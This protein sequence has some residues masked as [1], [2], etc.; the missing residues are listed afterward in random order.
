MQYTN[1]AFSY[2]ASQAGQIKDVA[3]ALG[4][5]EMAIAG[6]I[7]EEHDAF[8][9]KLNVQLAADAY[10]DLNLL[11]HTDIVLGVKNAKAKSDQV[12]SLFDKL[13]QPVLMDVGP[14][15]IKISTAVRLFENYSQE[16]MQQGSDP[17]GL[18]GY[19]NNYRHMLV[20]LIDQD[21]G[22]TAAMTGLMIKEADDFFSENS[23]PGYWESM[24]QEFRDAVCITYFN[25]GPAAIIKK[26]N[27]DLA[28]GKPYEPQPGEG[29][30]GGE[31]FREPENQAAIISALNDP[32][33]QLT[34]DPLIDID[35]LYNQFR[36]F[37]NLISLDKVRQAA[38]CDKST[39]VLS[40]WREKLSHP[41]S[42]SDP[43]LPSPTNPNTY[44]I[45]WIPGGDPLVL[46]LDG[47]GVETIAPN[48][49]SGALF[50]HNND[51][52]KTA[53]GWIKGDDGL[54]VRDLNGNG[55]IDNGAELFG[56][57]TR[58]ANGTK[59][60]DGFVALRDIDSNGD[61]KI[62][63]ADTAFSELKI[64]RDANQDGISQANELSTL[65]ELGIESLNATAAN[66]SF[67]PTAAGQQIITGAF[68]K[69]NGTTATLADLNLYQDNF[70]S[71]Y[72]THI[73]IPQEL[74][75]LPDEAGMG[76]LR[77][78]REAATLS[79]ALANVLTQYAAAETRTEQK[80][81]LGQLLFEWAKT[82]PNYSASPVEVINTYRNIQYDAN[83]TNVIY[84]RAGQSLPIYLQVIP[85]TY[86]DTALQQHTRVVDAALGDRVTTILFDI[87]SSQSADMNKS[88]TALADAIYADL[89]TQT[90]FKKYLNAVELSIT[91]TSISLDTSKVT[92]LFQDKIASDPYNGLADLIEF[93]KYA[94]D[95]LTGT[96]W[97][98]L[99]LM[100]N[101]L[102][103]QTITPEIQTLYQELNI[104]FS[105]ASG[106]NN[107]DI[108][109]G[110]AQDRTIS[111]S[112]GND[113][114]LGGSGNEMLAGGML[115]DLQEVA[116]DGYELCAERSAA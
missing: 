112:I 35:S 92:Q 2:V 25:N 23:A 27:E 33:A 28:Q 106:G 97:D 74:A 90:R 51:G 56:D 20:D 6:A 101:A 96:E 37:R 71:E 81:L 73:T 102:R 67:P 49:H 10:A 48:G 63:A 43:R 46:D 18:A 100:E 116:A 86:A 54:L 76:R 58:L 109:L 93:N 30:S 70:Y 31:T 57:S 108:L 15:N 64:W 24:T 65:A 52:I 111:G 94:G 66:M 104:R 40:T 1:Q 44:R 13:A 114:L 91:D 105:G 16:Y 17:L 79:P 89:L 107:D 7:A 41:T 32:E 47:D 103:T 22:L 113:I 8:L 50:D 26:M 34:T 5:S 62:N 12:V 55:T 9:S 78:L 36:N 99:G 45:V 4:L 11:S 84:L 69:T 77:N 115:R 72:T 95:M 38:H 3:V 29:P 98:G 19:Q 80:A 42:P 88:Y 60:A 61:S 85:K 68:T 53:T 110:D 75:E 59:A 82:D 21:S 87:F 14:A 83:S 39:N